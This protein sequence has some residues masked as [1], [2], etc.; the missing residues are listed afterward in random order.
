MKQQ[1][2]RFLRLPDVLDRTALSRSVVYRYMQAGEFPKQIK[3][4]STAVWSEQ[5]VNQWIEE[6]KAGVSHG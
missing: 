5:Q 6:K 1:N 3:L 4:G 2:D